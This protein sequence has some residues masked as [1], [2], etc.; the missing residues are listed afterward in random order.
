MAR[1][2]SSLS[3]V[4]FVHLGSSVSLRSFARLGS[5]VS[6]MGFSHVGASLSLRSFAR[7]GSALSVFGVARFGSLFSLSVMDY[8][9]LGASVSLR[10]LARVGAAVSV[11]DFANIGSSMSLR[12][13]ARLGSAFSLFGMA[14][15]GASVSVLDYASFGSSMSVRGFVR[16][17]G[18]LSVS[19][20]ILLP[21][22]QAV[23][24]KT[25]NTYVHR[26]SGTE[27]VDVYVAA[28]GVA[29]RSMS[30]ETDGGGLHGSWQTDGAVTT[31][32]RR[33]KTNVVSL[34]RSLHD[35]AGTKKTAITSA[36]SGNATAGYGDESASA[37][38]LLRQLRPV[39][40]SFRKGPESKQMRFGFIADELESVVPQVVR[41]EGDLQVTD[42]K[43]VMYQD[44]V[45]LLTTGVQEQQRSLQDQQ[46]ILQEQRRALQ[47]LRSRHDQV[48]ADII[49]L[50]E[51]RSKRQKTYTL[52]KKRRKARR[53]L[54]AFHSRWG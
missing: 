5:A 38:W 2:G 28:S 1:L 49:H 9:H 8:V 43:A 13:Y 47:A 17:G 11:F 25:A 45:A 19:G 12:S 29:T 21:G 51:K 33:L 15:L 16:I 4:D 32:D 39:S 20:K 7:V 6:V 48:T 24:F 44:L 26:D 53:R 10:S 42:Q 27:N 34:Q 52:K 30:L 3:V 54:R 41:N 18:Q 31:S 35:L 50:K 37:L 40:Y 22:S 36:G 14:R 46:R 23:T